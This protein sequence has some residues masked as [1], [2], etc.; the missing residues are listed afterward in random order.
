MLQYAAG[1][2]L[3]DL[4]AE[5]AAKI[6]VVKKGAVE[7]AQAVANL[8]ASRDL[9][10]SSAHALD[11]LSHLRSYF[12]PDVC[13]SVNPSTPRAAAGNTAQLSRVHLDLAVA[14]VDEALAGFPFVGVATA[15]VVLQKQQSRS[16][17]G[18]SSAAGP[19]V[20]VVRQMR[21]HEV[22]GTRSSLAVSHKFAFNPETEQIAAWTVCFD[23]AVVEAARAKAAKLNEAANIKEVRAA[24]EVKL[25]R[26][27]ASAA[28]ARS[29]AATLRAEGPPALQPPSGGFTASFLLPF[30]REDIYKELA[31]RDK[32]LGLTSPYVTVQITEG[33][34]A[35]ASV[36]VGLEIGYV[37]HTQFSEPFAGHTTSELIGLTPGYELRWRQLDSDTR[38]NL[39][40]D[41]AEG[42]EPSCT[43]KLTDNATGGTEVTMAYAFASIEAKGGCWFLAGPFLPL[44][45]R[46]QLMQNAQ[47]G[48]K[49]DMLERGYAIELSDVKASRGLLQR[50]R[51]QSEEAAMKAAALAKAKASMGATGEKEGG[52]LCLKLN[53]IKCIQPKPTMEFGQT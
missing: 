34:P 48:W 14:A 46:R 23:A 42:R 50:R 44:L 35:G 18:R 26:E 47:E 30:K 19:S 31:R 6:A 15:S 12:E 22:S 32:P 39:V 29:R 53:C 10:K 5:E 43:I 17:L 37:R 4:E 21:T 45:L 11:A 49:A 1:A 38:F 33:G 8:L 51:D 2:Y 36:G 20:V 13:L 24:A 28:A 25:Q 52:N 3:S 41:E 9:A 16:W 27:E 40:G 7:S